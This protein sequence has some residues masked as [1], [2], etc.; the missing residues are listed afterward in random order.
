[1]GVVRREE[2][3]SRLLMDLD[4]PCSLVITPLLDPIRA[5][6]SDSVDVRLGQTFLLPRILQQPYFCPDRHSQDTLYAEVFVPLG[7]Y[8]IVPAH[9]TVLGSTLEFIKVPGDLSGE[10]LTKSSVARTFIVIETAPWVHPEYRGCL[11]LEIANVSNTPVLLYPGRTIGQLIFMHL[12]PDMTAKSSQVAPEN[13]NKLSPTYFGP[14]YPEGPKFSDPQQDLADIGVFETWT[15]EERSP[16]EQA[17]RQR[18]SPDEE[19]RIIRDIGQHIKNSFFNVAQVDLSLRAPEYL[20]RA[21]LESVTV[22]EQDP[23]AGPLGL[24]TAMVDAPNEPFGSGNI[25]GANSTKPA[26]IRFNVGT[27]LRFAPSAYKS[28]HDHSIVAILQVACALWEMVHSAKITLTKKQV[29][30]FRAMWE[31]SGGERAL[32]EGEIL[33]RSQED[34]SSQGLGALSAAELES[35]LTELQMIRCIRATNTHPRTWIPTEQMEYKY[36]P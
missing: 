11:T 20:L 12:D 28:V 4:D 18:E 9:Q 29:I 27:L 23:Q 22:T 14:V 26:N 24:V 36:R 6:D 1:M 32:G 8:L 34:F 16:S 31:L 21:T 17:T 35:L 2:L 5:F 15:I 33:K 7:R 3:Q 25:S 13:R 10:I 30:V 19:A